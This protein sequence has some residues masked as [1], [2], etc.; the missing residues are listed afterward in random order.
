MSATADNLANR[1]RSL[2]VSLRPPASATAIA[3]AERTIGLSLPAEVRALYEASDGSDWVQSP[4]IDFR[5]MRLD[6][7]LELTRWLDGLRSSVIYRR[8]GALFCW[9]DDNSNHAGLYTRGPLAGLVVLLD[10]EGESFAPAYW[11]LTRFT[12]TLV[13]RAGAIGTWP[14]WPTDF[15]VFVRECDAE[16]CGVA[17][18][19]ADTMLSLAQGEPDKAVRNDLLQ[20]AISLLPRKRANDMIAM[21]DVPDMWVPASAADLL[22]K[23]KVAEA[24]PQLERL[25]AKRYPNG[26]SASLRAL[27]RIGTPA[28]RDALLRLAPRP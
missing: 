27:E 4:A 2:G 6:E 15:P 1:L 26:E 9:T 13:A 21:L 22:G 5:P 7:I 3:N 23:A 19:L 11:R 12:E 24:V 20:C 28:A 18:S 25:A 17:G 14:D 16:E 8:F 10:H